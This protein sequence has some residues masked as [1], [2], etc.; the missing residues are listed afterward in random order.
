M[1]AI[2]D[3]RKS[4]QTLKDSGNKINLR[5]IAIHA[6]VAPS[7]L[8]KEEAKE[9]R[10]EILDAEKEWKRSKSIQDLE[11]ELENTKNKLKKANNKIKKLEEISS[12]DQQDIIEVL[13]KKLDELYNEND[14]LKKD[15]RIEREN[16]STEQTEEIRFD[17]E[18]GE[19]ISGVKFK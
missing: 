19:I 18:T 14:K 13:I 9:V 7:Y 5:Q 2:D 15:L 12:S 6:D 1:S 17:E 10:N 16:N 3:L 8:N 4:L 11:Q